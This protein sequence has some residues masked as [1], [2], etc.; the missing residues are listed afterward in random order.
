MRTDIHI[1]LMKHPITKDIAIVKDTN[2][3]KQSLKNITYTNLYERGFNIVGASLKHYLFELNDE[4][5]R[6]A[7]STKLTSLYNTY[8]P[9]INVSSVDIYGES[10]VIQ[11]VVSYTEYNNS[12][13]Q[14]LT[15]PIKAV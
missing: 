13:E 14:T 4:L 2:A 3:I 9:D 6:S 10:D 5:M 1:G 12:E 8:E 15:I 11:I 7:L